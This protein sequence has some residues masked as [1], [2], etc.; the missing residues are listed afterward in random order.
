MKVIFTM[1][2]ALSFL[3]LLTASPQAADKLI[4]DFGGLSGFQST[5]WVAKDLKIF[6]KHGLDVDVIMINGSARS[7]VE[8]LGPSLTGAP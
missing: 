5:V 2:S 7:V 3:W 1:F 4:A 6:D 8:V